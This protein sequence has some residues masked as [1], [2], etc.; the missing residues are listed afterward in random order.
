MGILNDHKEKKP[1]Y[2]ACKNSC[3]KLI[4]TNKKSDYKNI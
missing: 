2:E 3:N 4:K 1:C